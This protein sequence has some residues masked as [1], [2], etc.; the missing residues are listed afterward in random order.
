MNL[1]ALRAQFRSEADDSVS[2]YLFADAELNDWLNQAVEEAA[3]RADLLLEVDDAAVCTID[4]TAATSAY[5]LHAKITRVTYASFLADGEDATDATE[6]TLTD[7]IKL[8]RIRPCWR[9]E[10]DRPIYLLTENGTAR[11]VPKPDANGTLTLEAYRLPMTAMA[12]DSDSPEIREQHHRYLV[13]WALFRA[14]SKP[15][16]ETQDLPR[17][18]A[19]QTRFEDH[20]GARPDADMKQSDERQPHANAAFYW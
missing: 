1:A 8:D 6:L 9:T 3:I 13:D 5:P 18:Q 4:V 12:D 10:S 11:L 20:F 16:T 15:D 7:R 2:P 19:A 14:Y 17:A